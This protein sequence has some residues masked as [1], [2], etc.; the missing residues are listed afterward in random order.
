MNKRYVFEINDKGDLIFYRT[1]NRKVYGSKYLITPVINDRGDITYRKYKISSKTIDYGINHIDS[2]IILEYL[3]RCA[4]L[5]T[6]E[7]VVATYNSGL[8]TFNILPVN[9]DKTRYFIMKSAVDSITNITE[10]YI[11]YKVSVI[12]TTSDHNII[13]SNFYE[14]KYIINTKDNV[15]V[16][17]I[18]KIDIDEIFIDPDLDKLDTDVAKRLLFVKTGGDYRSV[19]EHNNS[20]DNTDDIIELDHKTY[21]K[22]LFKVLVNKNLL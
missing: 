17:A 15:L 5:M 21:L 19:I 22:T 20:T 6:V 13:N 7:T 12:E 8:I 1:V 16:D 3:K 18:I 9:L 2:L 10:D 14:V 4:D 11:L